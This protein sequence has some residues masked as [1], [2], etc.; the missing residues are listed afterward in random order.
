MSFHWEITALFGGMAILSVFL[1]LDC[2]RSGGWFPRVAAVAC[3]LLMIAFTV[4]AALP[5]F[6]AFIVPRCCLR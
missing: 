3:L 4:F 2:S 5:A 1:G 6:D